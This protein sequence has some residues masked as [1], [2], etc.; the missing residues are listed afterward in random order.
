MSMYA[1]D[2]VAWNYLSTRLTKAC[3]AG[4]SEFSFD[5]EKSK[6]THPLWNVLAPLHKHLNGSKI[7]QQRM[8]LKPVTGNRERECGNEYKALFKMANEGKEKGTI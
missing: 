3:Y 4:L 5:N 6:F 2:T 7:Y 8:L 1:T